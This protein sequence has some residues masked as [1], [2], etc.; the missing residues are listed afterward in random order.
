MRKESENDALQVSSN[1][2]QRIFRAYSTK[3]ENTEVIFEYKWQLYIGNYFA[4]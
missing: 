1:L 3:K 2:M 4:N